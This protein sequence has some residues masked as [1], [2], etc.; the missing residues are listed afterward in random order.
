VGCSVYLEHFGLRELPFAL[1]PNTQF[2]VNMDSH[3]EAYNLL[4]VAIANGEGFIKLVA[5]VGTGKTLLCRKVLNTLA[6]QQ[7]YVTAYIANPVL[8]PR[9]LVLALAEELGLEV[10]VDIA[11]HS[12]LRQITTCLVE[13]AAAG[14][15]VVLFIDEAHAMP[16]ETLEALRLMTNLETETTK[17]VQVVMFGQPELDI[18]LRK[19]SLRQLLQRITFSCRLR[20]LNREAVERYVSHRL[21]TAGYNGPMLFSRRAMDL[22]S[23]ASA[24]VPRLLNVLAHKALMVAYGRGEQRVVRDHVRRAV[25][26]TEGV[27]H[28]VPGYVSRVLAAL[29]I[30]S[31]GAALFYIASHYL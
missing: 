10:A 25:I 28:K 12:L 3:R 18:M 4:M 21:S 17:L 15:Q 1:T 5:E 19:Q 20:A 6:Q 14:R 23:S 31:V 24:G 16:E 13:H 30:L 26:D 9:G 7:R 8:S 22:L 29:G 11:Q 2:F 27:E